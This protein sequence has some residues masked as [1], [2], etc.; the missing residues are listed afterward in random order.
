MGM[1]AWINGEEQVVWFEVVVE[2][3]PRNARLEGYIH[4]VRS[5]GEYFIHFL[6]RDGDGWDS[7]DALTNIS[8]AKKSCHR[9]RGSTLPMKSRQS[10]GSQGQ[11]NPPQF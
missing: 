3:V 6:E 8:S 7:G 4:V 5:K 9:G 11:S 2:I 1:W 10:K